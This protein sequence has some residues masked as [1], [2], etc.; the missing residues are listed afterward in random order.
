M[1]QNDLIV[2][3]VTTPSADTA[4]EIAEKLLALH[5]AAC[6][7]IV[8]GVQSIYWWKE[9]MERGDEVLM[10]IKSTAERFAELENAIRSAHPYETPEIVA[11]PAS[12]VFKGYLDWVRKETLKG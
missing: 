1:E 8:P 9:Q 2:V 4:K 5:V 12:A 7:N 10:L 6:V 3:L 11:L